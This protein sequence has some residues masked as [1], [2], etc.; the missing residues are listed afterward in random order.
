M[1]TDKARLILKA[2][3]IQWSNYF[4]LDFVEQHANFTGCG[5]IL[6]AIKR[7]KSFILNGN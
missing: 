5:H 7:M 2:N 6:I 3:G 1:T 4:D